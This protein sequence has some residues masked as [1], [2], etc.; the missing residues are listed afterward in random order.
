MRAEEGWFRPQPFVVCAVLWLVLV[1]PSVAAASTPAV[2]RQ[3]TQSGA[4][5]LES[6]TV[7]GSTR[8]PS[9]QVA[10]ATR[11]TIGQTVTKNDIQQAADR[12]AQL[13]PFTNVQYHFSTAEGGVKI[14]YQVTDGPVLPVL[15]DNFPWLAD[16]ELISGLRTSVPLFDGTAPEHGTILDDMSIALEELLSKRGVNAHVTHDVVIGSGGVQRLAQ[17]RVEGADVIIEAAEFSDA[18][19]KSDRGIQDRL[20]DLI[21]KPFSR[22]TIELF[23]LEQVRP[24]YLAHAFLR[25]QFGPA[26]ARFA[27]NANSVSP[28]RVVVTVPIDPGPRFTWGS[29]TWSGN[30]AVPSTVLNGLVDLKTDESADGMKIDATWERVRAAFSQRGYLDV[31]LTPVPQFDDVAKRVA[32]A[33]SIT[34]GQQYHMGELVLTGLSLEGERRIRAAWSIAQGAA[35]NE[36]VYEEFL[37]SGI[38]R[39]LAGLPVHYEKIGRF[40]QKDS[41]TGKVDV[42]LDF[43]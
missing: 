11:L 39:A 3:N 1:F 17:F 27:G 23:E 38:K 2:P 43:Q 33:V 35:F 16:Q 28:N 30:A 40:L 25:V 12:L 7:T 34:E 29:V 8:F 13:G 15:F 42:L 19:A 5:R 31:N 6:I 10:L 21:G 24:V 22:T 14:E 26:G 36:G 9:G 4:G 20:S 18:L 32:Y 41:K 37:D